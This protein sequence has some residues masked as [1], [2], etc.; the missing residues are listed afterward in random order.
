MRS[1][2]AWPF[3][4]S[5]VFSSLVDFVFQQVTALDSISLRPR[6]YLST[7]E[8]LFHFIFFEKQ[9]KK[10]YFK[11]NCYPHPFC[12]Q[13]IKK[14]LGYARYRELLYGGAEALIIS[15]A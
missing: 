4:V 9:S 5:S 7:S 8:R 13:E 3:D 2:G 10:L 12:T 11:T 1:V 6:K 15:V 14:Q